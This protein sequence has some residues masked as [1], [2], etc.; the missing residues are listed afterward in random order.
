MKNAPIEMK[1]ILIADDAPINRKMLGFIFQEQFNVIE[2]EN[3]QVAIEILEKFKDEIS[4]IFLDLMMPIKTGIDVLEYMK[5]IGLNNKVPVIMITGESTPESDEKAYQLGVSEIIY[6]PFDERVVMR[7]TKNTIELFENRN[8]L[9]KKLEERTKELQKSKEVLFHQNQF[10][11][12]ALGSVL[13]LRGY[14]S[15]EHLMRVRTFTKIMMGYIKQLYPEYELTDEQVMLISEAAIL[16][17]LGKVAVPEHIIFK[18]TKYT[19]EEME[20]FEKHTI[21]GCKILENFKQQQETELYK[22]CYD[23]CRYHHERAD[24][25]GYPFNI[26]EDKIPIWSQV[27]GLV[28]SY[29]GL[30]N[31]RLHKTPYDVKIAS[32]KVKD[33]DCGA[34]S[35]K[36]LKAFELAEEEMFTVAAKINYVI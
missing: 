25:K 5:E 32:K 31:P 30:I 24:G 20:E 3:G 21:Y 16:H 22:Y 33:G 10:L 35:E 13:E 7:R 27:V 14:E 36:V 34:F 15:S 8:A 11:V 17:D 23:I 19:D 12:N 2:A 4:I 1:T 9:E 6:K 28:D 18:N 29:D 26:K